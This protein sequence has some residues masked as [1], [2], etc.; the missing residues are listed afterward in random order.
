MY[1]DDGMTRKDDRQAAV[2]TLVRRGRTRT[3][4]QMLKAL[5]ARRIAVDQSTLSRD[6]TELGVRKA[7]GYYVPTEPDRRT[8]GSIDYASAVIAF[9]TCGPY[10]IA[11]RTGT[12]QAQPVALMIEH[13]REPAVAATLA[14]DDTIFLATK[15]RRAQTVVLRR[16]KNWFG[17]KHEH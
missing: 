7:G 12:G 13:A 3:Q 10:M 2:L 5:R 4:A 11:V 6:L 9:T 14:G 8:R 16:L 15:G 17:D 1:D